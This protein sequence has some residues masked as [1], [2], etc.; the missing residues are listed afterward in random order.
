MLYEAIPVGPISR[1]PNGDNK[2]TCS[3]FEPPIQIQ[4]RI[5]K[6][7]RWSTDDMNPSQ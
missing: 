7:P 2:E 6:L 4:R 3:D 1:S 5:D